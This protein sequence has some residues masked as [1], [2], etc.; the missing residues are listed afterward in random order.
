M[1]T[2][3]EISQEYQQLADAGQL[4]LEVENETMPVVEGSVT[5]NQSVPLCRRGAV[6]L[7][8][9]ECRKCINMLK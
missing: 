8:D 1:E 2:L 9:T 7:N 5:S 4:R 3:D 6:L